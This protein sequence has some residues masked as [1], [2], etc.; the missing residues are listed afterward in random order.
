[1]LVLSTETEGTLARA[2]GGAFCRAPVCLCAPRSSCLP[3]LVRPLVGSSSGGFILW[4]FALTYEQH[5]AYVTRW[6]GG[7]GFNRNR[8]LLL[9]PSFIDGLTIRDALFTDGA[10]WQVHPM[11]CNHVWITRKFKPKARRTVHYLCS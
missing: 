11:F 4:W 6:D 5:I 8:P 7:A 3:W 10:N 9:T 2:A 1:M